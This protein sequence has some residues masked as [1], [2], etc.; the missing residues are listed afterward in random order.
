MWRSGKSGK[1]RE[2]GEGEG[3]DEQEGQREIEQ[4]QG[5]EIEEREMKG[6]KREKVNECQYK[7]FFEGNE[8]RQNKKKSMENFE[9][10]GGRK[11]HT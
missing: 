7:K 8:T 3:G 5:K 2:K 11:S 4:D 10:S 6:E 9:Y 1:E